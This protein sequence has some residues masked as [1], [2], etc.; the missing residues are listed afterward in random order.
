MTNKQ[1]KPLV[2][3]LIPVYNGIPYLVETVESVFASTRL[4]VEVILVDDGSTDGSKAKCRKLN[5]KYFQVTYIDF[6]QNGG[7]TRCLNAG[8]KQAMGKYVARINQDDLMVKGR[9][10][11]QVKFLETHPDHVAVGSFIRM[12]TNDNPDFDVVTF[13]VT[14]EELKRVWLTLSPF[15]DPSV[16]YRKDAVLKTKGYSQ[17]MWP[18]D[19]VHMWYQL[20]S[21]GK[22]A[23]IPEFLTKVRW[24]EGAGSIRSHRL[25][26]QKTWEVHMWAAQN[27]RK[28]S[29]GEYAFWSIQYLAGKALPPQV[30]WFVYRTLRKLWKHRSISRHLWQAW[31]KVAGVFTYRVS[32]FRSRVSLGLVKLRTDK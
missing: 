20:G 10:E 18:A 12:F 24:H 11:K 2:S 3:V 4:P 29:V 16:M 13:P 6:K 19:D 5:T 1:A 25:Q 17:T 28:P 15:S 27:I 22:L 32:W 9:L 23:N 14:D 8:I 30:N 7:M 26:M 31:E 21:I